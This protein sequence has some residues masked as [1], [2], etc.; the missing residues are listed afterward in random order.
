MLTQEFLRAFV[1]DQR[2][3]RQSRAWEDTMRAWAADANHKHH[4]FAAKTVERWD[5]N[6]NAYL[7]ERE[8]WRAVLSPE[9][10]RAYHDLEWH[11]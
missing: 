7:D 4:E 3:E 6:M 8:S 5:E 2:R 1:R 9:Q 11:P 10:W